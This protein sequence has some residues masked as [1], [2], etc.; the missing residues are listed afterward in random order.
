MQEHPAYAT[1][2]QTDVM[3][4]ILEEK[5]V[6]SFTCDQCVY[7]CEAEDG[8]LIKKPTSVM[9]NAKKFTKELT[10]RCHGRGGQCGRPDGWIH[11]QCRW[12]TARLA[13]MYHFELCRAICVGCRRQLQH[14]GKCRDGF[15]GM[16]E[17]GMENLEVGPI[18][19]IG[20]SGHVFEMKVDDENIFRD[21]LTGQVLDPTLVRAA[22]KKELD[23]FEAKGVWVTKAM[24]EARRKTGKP[25]IT[26]RRADANKGDDVE[27]GIRS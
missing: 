15:V 19:Q 6:T 18:L 26:V 3:E 13:A 7:G 20:Y 27:P 23:F 8:S 22:R 4:K 16:L 12:K 17:S 14:D 11:K 25:P 21:D 2:W 10:A 1:S 24:E 9:S 5:G